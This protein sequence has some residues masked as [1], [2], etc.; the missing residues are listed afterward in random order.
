MYRC[1]TDRCKQDMIPRNEMYDNVLLPFLG[2]W[3]V[4]VNG[5]TMSNER[6]G[7]VQDYRPLV[8][9]PILVKLWLERIMIVLLHKHV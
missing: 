5:A 2:L 9:L 6:P 7:Q 4:L 8:H 1:G 3:S